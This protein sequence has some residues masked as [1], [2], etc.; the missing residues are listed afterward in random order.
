MGSPIKVPQSNSKPYQS[1]EET[2]KKW[3]A[4]KDRKLIFYPI[5][6]GIVLLVEGF[7]FN[8]SKFLPALDP[9]LFESLVQ[10]NATFLGFTIVGFFYYLGKIDDRRNDYINSLSSDVKAQEDF[11]SENEQRLKNALAA[12]EKVK[13]NK[14]FHEAE[15]IRLGISVISQMKE[16]TDTIKSEIID[17]VKIFEDLADLIRR[18]ISYIILSY[19]LGIVLSFIA[20]FITTSVLTK[21]IPNYTTWFL[22][23][24]AISSIVSTSYL[25]NDIWK[26][27]QHFS[28]LLFKLSLRVQLSYRK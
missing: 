17:S 4:L 26:S 25:F 8:Y 14:K 5:F 10:V 2:R 21:Y 24:G 27:L 3:V 23:V 13:D 19:G 7:I 18:D 22:L 15:D 20:L 9:K 16:K 28:D 11:F 6:V 1:D 12:I